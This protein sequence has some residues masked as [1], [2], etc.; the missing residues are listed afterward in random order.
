[1]LAARGEISLTTALAREARKKER[2]LALREMWTE[3]PSLSLQQAKGL[4]LYI[5]HCQIWS[6]LVSGL[7]RTGMQVRSSCVQ[8]VGKAWGQEEGETGQ[9]GSS[10]DGNKPQSL[11]QQDDLHVLI[12]TV[13]SSCHCSCGCDVQW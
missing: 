7:C 13:N 3:T 4:K 11:S 6:C 8:H 9:Q 2:S 5:Q 10:L 1:M 12:A